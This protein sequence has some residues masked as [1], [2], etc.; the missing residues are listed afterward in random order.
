MATLTTRQIGRV[1]EIESER[2]TVELDTAIKGMVK[3]GMFGVQAVG[4]IN[5]YVTVTAG[6]SN[7]VALVTAV[8]ILQEQGY[9]SPT[10]AYDATEGAIRR[11]EATMIGRLVNGR[12]ESGVTTY[13]SLLSPVYVATEAVL[14]A[15]F[16][17]RSDTIKFG[18]TAIFSDYSVGLDPD[19]LLPRHFAILGM[20]GTGKSCSVLAVLD[21]LHELNVKQSN[22]IIF[23][24]NG[25]YGAAFAKDTERARRI[26]SFRIGPILGRD[27]ITVPLW[28]MNNDEHKELL[29]AAE[30][31]Q[32]PI[33]QRSIADARLAGML[34]GQ[35]LRR[36][37][38]IRQTLDLISRVAISENKAQ[39][40]VAGQLEGLRSYLD[41]FC[42]TGD[43]LGS[44]W[45]QMRSVLDNLVELRLDTRSWDPL[46]A[47][48]R[49]ELLRICNDLRQLYGQAISAVTNDWSIPATDVDAP[50]HYSF[51]DL[52][53]YFLPQRLV[54]ES[55]GDPRILQ[56]V[57]GLQMRM[58]RLL[59]DDRYSFMTRV[60]PFDSALGSFLRL[61]LGKDPL[62]VNSDSP[63]KASYTQAA[64]HKV[65]G[66]SVT[67]VDLGHIAS[68]VLPTVTALIARLVIEM[69][70]RWRPRGGMPILL[71]LEEAHRYV[72]RQQN[73]KRTQSATTFERIAKEG[74]K[75]GVSL[76]LASQRPSEIDPTVLS[77]CGTVIVHRLT[78][79]VD[80][81]FIRAAAPT[82][83]R[84]V[85]RQLPSLATQHAIV[86]GDAVPAPTVVKVRTVIN[87]PDSQDPSFVEMW[88]GSEVEKEAKQIS[89]I[90][91]AWE[92]G[93]R[94]D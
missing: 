83:T 92:R 84:D 48:Q 87:P 60:E 68:D 73:E 70:Q 45:T 15:I 52:A 27:G 89:R 19:R 54:F 88:R 76:C 37:S 61:L 9:V 47:Q 31:V 94:T 24:T 80:Q 10:A 65:D 42:N 13:P 1:T 5:S 51:D 49:D 16:P 85:L 38:V 44:Y 50:S 32:A 34:H 6:G 20:T 57:A 46:D 17:S 36:L 81:D 59:S 58:A 63:W 75:F 29:Q 40:K 39:E 53:N 72:T 91:E 93:E 82:A 62:G 12:F 4:A 90:A 18:D 86:L 11:I 26:S 78:S 55:D 79:Q 2:L 33:L 43:S 22:V 74:R 21:G 23:D 69:A 25:E 7:V 14:G 35:T 30:G 28:F 66:H 56:Y 67:I 8:R 71:V 64:T 3:S 77:Q 41:S